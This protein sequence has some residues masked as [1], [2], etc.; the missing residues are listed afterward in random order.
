MTTPELKP[1][2]RDAVA[3]VRAQLGPAATD[4][5]DD[6]ILRFLYARYNWKTEKF[7]T[8]ASVIMLSSSL[9]WRAETRAQDLT[10]CWHSPSFNQY[11]PCAYHGRDKEGNHV[12][13]ER[14]GT[15]K[16]DELFTN[17]DEDALMKLH[18]IVMET[19]RRFYDK[20]MGGRGSGGIVVVMDLDGLSRS[21]LDK[22]VF[23]WLRG[24]AAIDK[25][26]YPE[27]LVKC[28]IINVGW[29]FRGAWAMIYPML[30]KRTA[31]KVELL[32]G[33]DHYMPKLLAQMDASII[34][35][36]FGG[37]CAAC[38]NGCLTGYRFG[39]LDEH[40]PAGA[41]TIAELKDRAARGLPLPVILSASA[42]T[43]AP[44]PPTAASG[45]PA[46]ERRPSVERLPTDAEIEAA[47]SKAQ[48]DDQK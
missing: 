20:S 11:Y 4:L 27:H 14:P 22:R 25:L 37:K 33:K 34:P 48:S 13:F 8:D 6:Y 7:D 47:M 32:G 29:V 45:A 5:L 16:I 30:D 36:I 3:I 12:F 38:P 10:T 43:G 39:S 17:F 21:H 40:A 18:L 19:G 1:N 24:A 44:A 23:A 15:M 28:F 2:E 9:K 46:A 26:N 41:C 42:A 35:A 31:E